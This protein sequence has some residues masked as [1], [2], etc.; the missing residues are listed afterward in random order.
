MQIH[1]TNHSL[2]ISIREKVEKKSSFSLGASS[3][4]PYPTHML[5]D[6]LRQELREEADRLRLAADRIDDFLRS[7]GDAVC[8][9]HG[10]Q[11][12]PCD[13]VE[14]PQR[15]NGSFAG[16]VRTALRDFG[17]IATSRDVANFMVHAGEPK[18]KGGKPLRHAVA[19]ELFRMSKRGTHVRKVDRG[20][21]QAVVDRGN[22]AD[23][24]ESG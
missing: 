3:P 8:K 20:K 2:H 13:P 17:R 1:P 16:R 22:M 19:I 12:I 10:D 11:T 24:F 4:G 7:I 18:T 14:S 6:R 21:Y 5:N 9:S 15:N 23:V